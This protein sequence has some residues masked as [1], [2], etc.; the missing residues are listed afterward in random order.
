MFYKDER[1]AIFIDGPN[2]FSTS[3]ALGF[4]IDY[5]LLRNEFAR[6]G[7]L[8]SLRYYTTLL[9]Q[10]DFVPVQPL[11]DWLQYNGFSVH[12]KPAREFVDGAGQRKIKGNIDVELAVDAV[13]IAPH[14]DHV[15]LFSGNGDFRSLVACLQRMGRRVSIVST[16]K[17]SPAMASDDLRRQADH[18]IEL[19]ALKDII[20]RPPRDFDLNDG[21]IKV[22]AEAFS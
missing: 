5:K 8:L 3:K 9:E 14:V 1:L 16:V 12:T 18:F 20:G 19:D 10:D 22:P 7:R 21:Q 2:L 6:R 17:T 4:D 13:E 11:L 15:V